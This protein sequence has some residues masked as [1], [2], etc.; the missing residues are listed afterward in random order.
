MAE[1]PGRKSP[2][3]VDAGSADVT[4]PLD[5]H[6][7]D[8]VTATAYCTVCKIHLCTRCVH[9]HKKVPVTKAHKLLMGSAMP[10]FTDSSVLDTAFDQPEHCPDHQKEEIKFFCTKHTN[11]CCVA[12]TVVKHQ[13]CKIEY[14]PDVSKDFAS[15]EEYKKLIERIQAIERLVA[16]CQADIHRC[17]DAVDTLSKDEIGIFRSFKAEIIAFLDKRET[18]LLTEIQRRR[19]ED[20]SI[21]QNLITQSESMKTTTEEMKRKLHGM[22]SNPERL[23]IWTKRFQDQ[24]ARLQTDVEEI[25]RKTGYQQYELKKDV[26]VE[27]VLNSA[28]GVATVEDVPGIELLVYS[29]SII[30]L[31]QQHF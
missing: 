4:K 5:C 17:K 21:L 10:L 18:Q 7:C 19:D 30:A 6:I 20:D 11:L 3:A 14:I 27:A 25:Q 16:Q 26:T 29:I 28:T 1:V 15:S 2:T 23:F 12:C 31:T 8:N 22:E 24:V 9:N 13:S